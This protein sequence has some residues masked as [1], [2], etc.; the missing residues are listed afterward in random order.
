VFDV[1]T[2]I[3]HQERLA[4]DRCN[5]DSWWQDIAYRC[6][7]SEAKFTTQTEEGDR[8]TER[9]FD[10]T[11]TTSLE[12]FSAVMDE[13]LTPRTQEW[14]GMD[15]E[16]AELSESWEAKRYFDRVTKAL[17]ARRYMPAAN[18]ASQK[19]QGYLSVG[20]FGNSVLFIDEQVS[21]GKVLPRYRQLPMR[22]CFWV[23]NHQ[24]RIDQ[25]YRRFELETHQAL[26]AAKEKGWKLPTKILEE[27]DQF[28]KWQFLHY[29]GPNGDRKPWML[30]PQ[31][32]EFVSHYVA[33]EG[34]Q[35][36]SQGGFKSWPFGIGRYT[37]TTGERYARSPIMLAWPAI[38]TLNEEKKTILR[39]G[40]KEVD[41][42]WLIHEDGVMEAFNQRP[43]AANYGMVTAGGDPLAIPLKAGA[44]IP[45]GLELMGLEKQAIEDSLLVTIFK[46][47][48]E[49]PSM[50]AT[51]V[52]E[53]AQQKAT[54]LAPVMGRQH[55]EDLGPM[56]EREFQLLADAEPWVLEEMPEELIEAGGS[57]KITYKSPL[58]R[59]M[60]AQ[61]GVAIM[62]TFEVMGAAAQIDPNA[63][64]IIDVP[65]A[66]REL[67]DINGVPAKLVRDQAQV[68]ALLEQKAE[69]EAEANAVAVAPELSQAALNAA[70]A[71]QIRRTA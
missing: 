5:F 44:N 26:S 50:T 13:L 34:R 27:R 30:G 53:I 38:L 6:L 20:A 47:L 21:G 8:R 43:G 11:A 10:S 59:A 14:H 36:V 9:L 35:T 39:A 40:Q 16:A 45:L 42:P 61:D 41:P 2:L 12:R 31:G 64:L 19:H 69:A 58:A 70:K 4:S 62:R 29:V 60:R 54:L 17:F 48:S 67:A 24:G 1:D 7:P 51:Q 37:V 52:L 66:L 55:A 25:M 32:M 57:Y 68:E 33:L 23:E 18:F 56:I 63:A 15:A 65:E 71:E 49:H 3:K 28:K 22:E 46:I